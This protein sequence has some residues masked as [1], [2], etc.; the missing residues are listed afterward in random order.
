MTSNIWPKNIIGLSFWLVIP[1]RVFLDFCSFKLL[2]LKGI[3]RKKKK[4][5]MTI[6]SLFLSFCYHSIPM[7]HYY[8][9]VWIIE[10]PVPFYVFSFLGKKCGCGWK[11]TAHHHPG[12]LACPLNSLL[13]FDK[14]PCL[15]PHVSFL[16]SLS[17]HLLLL[18]RLKKAVHD[19]PF[20]RW[21]TYS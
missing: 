1:I 14:T 9:C 20:I 19:P 12:T 11:H 18:L 15:S 10:D 6:T 17:F 8:I 4:L 21:L 2:V 3:K 5:E 13:S 16:P 7:L